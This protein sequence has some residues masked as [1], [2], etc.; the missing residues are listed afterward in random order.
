[1][2]RAVRENAG[3]VR[4]ENVRKAGESR[5]NVHRENVPPVQ[6]NAAAVKDV[7]TVKEEYGAGAGAD[8]R[9]AEGRNREKDKGVRV[10]GGK[11]REVKVRG[12]RDRGESKILPADR[13][14][15]DRGVPADSREVK[16]AVP[17]AAAGSAKCFI[18]I[19]TPGKW[20]VKEWEVPP[21]RFSCR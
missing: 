9:K 2:P 1:V 21:I 4:R 12:V 10:K 13:S 18:S 6:E 16:A 19:R 7:R 17:V 11:A 8:R 14:K 3:N 20:S 15:E 5:A